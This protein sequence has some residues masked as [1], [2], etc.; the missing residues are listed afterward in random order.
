MKKWIRR[1]VVP[2][3]RWPIG[4]YRGGGTT[5][6][7]MPE[8]KRRNSLE[9]RKNESRSVCDR[10]ERRL[11]W[12]TDGRLSLSHK[13]PLC[14]ATVCTQIRERERATLRLGSV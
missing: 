13:K 5:A 12:L 14:C 4:L 9:P 6:L 2:K 3:A 7:S 10:E 8:N 1:H 11:R